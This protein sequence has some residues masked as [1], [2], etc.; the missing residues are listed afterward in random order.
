MISEGRQALA[1]ALSI[2]AGI[3]GYEYRPT[4]P[5]PGDAWSL[6]PT[7]DLKEGLMWQATWTVVVFLP[8]DERAASLWIDERFE[9]IAA[10][11]REPGFVTKVEPAVMDAMGSDQY[12][13]KFTVMSE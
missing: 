4:T 7:L 12:V 10:A 5:R 9:A 3:R 13:L 11:L 6:L 2:V 1:S 8:Q